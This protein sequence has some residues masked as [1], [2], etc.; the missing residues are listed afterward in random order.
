VSWHYDYGFQYSYDLDHNLCGTS[1]D[2]SYI[3]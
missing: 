1:T 3:V 2:L